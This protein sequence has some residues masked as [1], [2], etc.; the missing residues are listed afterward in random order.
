MEKIKKPNYTKKDL[1]IYNYLYYHYN[2]DAY[3]NTARKIDLK[4]IDFST[5]KGLEKF[6]GQYE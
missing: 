5:S 6:V 4:S 1:L 2:M 3:E